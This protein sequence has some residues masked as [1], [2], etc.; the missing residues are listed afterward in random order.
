[1]HCADAQPSAPSRLT[2]EIDLF[3][4]EGVGKLFELLE[5]GVIVYPAYCQRKHPGRGKAP[6]G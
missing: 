2:S 3:F 6:H 4:I 1:M 5:A